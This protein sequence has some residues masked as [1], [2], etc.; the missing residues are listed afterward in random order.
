MPFGT[1]EIPIVEAKSEDGEVSIEQPE[2]LYDDAKVIISA[3]GK[4][5]RTYNLSFE[6]SSDREILITDDLQD[7]TP[8]VGMTGSII[9]PI[10]ASA[11]ELTEAQN[12][13]E[14]MIDGDFSTRCA[15]LGNGIWME[16]DLGKVTEFDG[17]ALG[18]FNGNTRFC[19]FDIL[20]S[21]DGINFKRVFSGHST[22]KTTGYES[23]SIPGKARYI[24]YVGYGNSNDASALW[25]SVTELAVY[26]NIN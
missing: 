13:P 12:G 18:L 22:G 26:S 5:D 14:K 1:E 9:M 15:V 17:V 6:V 7:A 8:E 24:R 11:S 20:Y 25:N 10:G 19:Y 16:V 4:R 23:L 2:T 21:E 3:P